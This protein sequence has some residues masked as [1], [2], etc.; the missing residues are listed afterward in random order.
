MTTG[1]RILMMQT[2]G[3]AVHSQLNNNNNNKRFL[4][5]HRV[6]LGSQPNKREEIKTT[7]M[8]CWTNSQQ[9]ITDK[10][11]RIM[12]IYQLW[13]DRFSRQLLYNST[14]LIKCSKKQLDC[15]ELTQ[16]VEI[17]VSLYSLAVVHYPTGRQSL[18]TSPRA[19]HHYDAPC[20]TKESCVFLIMSNGQV[21]LTIYSS[22]ILTPLLIDWERVSNRRK[23]IVVMPAN[24]NLYQSMMIL[25]E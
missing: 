6:T 12:K 3:A 10:L 13:K 7:W 23:A 25:K 22:V 24:A 5:L 16:S 18:H 1:M 4:L 9:R 21:M 11:N 19:V 2:E 14:E 8:I 20:A 17:N 15:K